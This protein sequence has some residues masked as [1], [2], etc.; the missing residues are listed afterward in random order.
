[1]IRQLA[2]PYVI[3]LADTHLYNTGDKFRIVSQPDYDALTLWSYNLAQCNVILA[4]AY[5]AYNRPGQSGPPSVCLR[6]TRNLSRLMPNRL[7][8]LMLSSGCR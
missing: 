8:I 2:H 3:R 4:R 7:A 5:K 1:M 6:D